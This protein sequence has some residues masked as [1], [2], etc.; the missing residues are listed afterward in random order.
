VRTFYFP[1][2]ANGE[3]MARAIGA[4][5]AARLSRAHRGPDEAVTYPL[6]QT[7]CPA[8]VIAFPS[9]SNEEEELR[10]VQAAYLREQAYAVF[11]GI[12]RMAEVPAEETLAVEITAAERRDW[13]V[14]LDATWTLCTGESGRVVF[15][16]VTP[17]AHQVR[18]RRA[19]ISV[20]RD[21]T[22]TDTEPS[23]TLSIDPGAR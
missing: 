21:I 14:T 6:Q 15:E 5:T 1:G 4:A 3:K 2:S 10:L 17:G 20:Q 13:M 9:I 8:V 11:T 18:V 12:L 19:G 23:A 7:A 22:T 16:N